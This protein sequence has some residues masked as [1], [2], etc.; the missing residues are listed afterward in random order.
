MHGNLTHVIIFTFVVKSGTPTDSELEKLSNELGDDWIWLGR[1]LIREKAEAKI[2]EFDRKVHLN[3]K[4]YQ[5]LLFWKQK[6]ASAA[7]YQVLFDALFAVNRG[8]L[9]Q[10]FCLADASAS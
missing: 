5:M 2:Q 10:A 4:A 1:Q 9:A 8:D 6:D 3:E 7:S